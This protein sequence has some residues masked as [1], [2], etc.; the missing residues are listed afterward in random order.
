MFL[1]KDRP[2]NTNF[3]YTFKPS[4]NY[5]P[6]V[7]NEYSKYNTK[8]QEKLPPA[9]R[10]GIIFLKKNEPF[11]DTQFLVVRG[12]ESGIWSFPKG[13]M[14]GDEDEEVCAIREVYEE[15]GILIDSLKG[16]EKLKIGRNTY[17][18]IYVDNIDDYK[19][20]SIKDTYEVDTVEWKSFS[21]LKNLSCNKDIRS[22]ITYPEKK[23]N[24]HNL[25]Y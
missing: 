21:E 5:K 11:N 19:D 6:R 17:F 2:S 9:K 18:I 7:F 4:W 24:Y 13:R 25:I 10:G 8:P 3:G 20:F 1:K 14:D 23:F 16:K 15:T 22:I 12:K